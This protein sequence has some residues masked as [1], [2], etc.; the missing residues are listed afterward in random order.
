MDPTQSRQHNSPAAKV[1]PCHSSCSKLSSILC[2]ACKPGNHSLPVSRPLN[3]VGIAQVLIYAASF[4]KRSITI[5]P[6]HKHLILNLQSTCTATSGPASQEFT[7]KGF[8]PPAVKLQAPLSAARKSYVTP[9]PV[10][11]HSK[12]A[13]SPKSI[14]LQTKGQVLEDKTCDGF[15]AWAALSRQRKLV[16][17]EPHN[18]AGK[19]CI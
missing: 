3:R 16:A 7:C 9:T 8:K 12:P 19:L 14:K 2:F 11:G 13:Q 15:E 10:G 1:S 6:G 18:S 5:A 17:A 4:T